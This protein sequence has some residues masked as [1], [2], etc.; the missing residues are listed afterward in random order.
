[1]QS[2]KAQPLSGEGNKRLKKHRPTNNAD[3]V[4][5]NDIDELNLESNVSVPFLINVK[6]AKDWVDNGSRL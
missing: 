4:A 2:K 5:W 6:E 1:M 3:T